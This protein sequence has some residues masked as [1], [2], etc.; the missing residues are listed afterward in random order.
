[1]SVKSTGSKYKGG[2]KKKV[3]PVAFESNDY[4][5]DEVEDFV[6]AEAPVVA[7]TVLTPQD[8]G[9]MQYGQDFL[10]K[11][12]SVSGGSGGSIGGK[13]KSSSNLTRKSSA[14]A[15]MIAAPPREPS[16]LSTNLPEVKDWPLALRKKI[17]ESLKNKHDEFKA[18]QLLTQHRWPE[19]L[20]TTVFKSVKRLPL[21]FFIV[22]DSGSM[23]TND[24]RRMLAQG[25]NAR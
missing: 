10:E 24:G 11:R 5:E 22:D 12:K 21:R 2:G 13:K 25:N 19:G 6:M 1:M 17:V 8:L 18:N 14:T 9:A 16:L 7:A 15:P 23:I 20:K 3:N 4:D